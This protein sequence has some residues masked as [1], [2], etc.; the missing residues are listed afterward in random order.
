M[1]GYPREVS[2]KIAALGPGAENDLIR[3]GHE[4]V[5]DTPRF[6]GKSAED[7]AMAFGGNDLSC[8]NCHLNAGLKPFAAPFVSTAA[9]FPM[10][11]DNKVV[12][13]S[14]VETKL[15]GAGSSVILPADIF[16][17]SRM[18]LMMRSRV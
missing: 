3:Y 12:T 7:P 8:Q 11:V 5:V 15:K 10:L 14:S 1:T 17:K 2:Q 18:S 16:E 13:S 4:L 9:A 6:I